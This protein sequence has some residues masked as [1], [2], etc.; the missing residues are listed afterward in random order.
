MAASKPTAQLSEAAN[1]LLVTLSQHLGTLTLGWIQFLTDAELTPDTLL[2][3]ST[4][5]TSLEFDRKPKDF[6]S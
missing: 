1:S 6:S 2:P 3:E 4:V 5:V